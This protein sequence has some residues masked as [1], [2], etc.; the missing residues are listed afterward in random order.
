M[1]CLHETLQYVGYLKPK[2]SQKPGEKQNLRFFQQV[3]E[4]TEGL[5][6]NPFP[7]PSKGWGEV[8]RRG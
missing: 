4:D 8:G 1:K 6:L 5:N 7:S 3:S 2:A